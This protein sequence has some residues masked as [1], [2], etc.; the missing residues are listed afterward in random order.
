M[1]THGR[2]FGNLISGAG[3]VLAA[4]LTSGCGGAI[5]AFTANSASSK[6]ETAEAL[7]A[8]KYAPYEYYTA[9]EHL[10]KAR[11]EAAAADYGDAIDF[12]DVAEE[13]AEK[14]ITLAKQAHEGAGR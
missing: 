11:E 1:T 6:L 2:R 3:L 10:W 8:A 7:G 5:Y 4:A 13:Y 12:A 14:A 9:R